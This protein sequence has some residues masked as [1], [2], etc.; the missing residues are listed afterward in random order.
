LDYDVTLNLY[1]ANLPGR[2]KSKAGRLLVMGCYQVVVPKFYKMQIQLIVYLLITLLLTFVTSTAGVHSGAAVLVETRYTD[3]LV[4]VINEANSYLPKNGWDIVVITNKNI[5]K[6]LKDTSTP[7]HHQKERK[8]IYKSIL[9]DTLDRN[10]Y[11]SLMKKRDLYDNTL[12]EYDWLIFFQTDTTFCRP[13]K[14]F[15][16]K[17]LSKFGYIGST[18]DNALVSPSK[19]FS[20]ATL[21]DHS[22]PR[23]FIHVGNGGFSLRNRK[24]MIDIIDKWHRISGHLPYNEDVW[25]ACG[26]YYNDILADVTTANEF[27]IES[28]PFNGQTMDRPFGV[29]KPWKYQPNKNLIQLIKACPPLKGLMSVNKITMKN[30]DVIDL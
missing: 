2:T 11:N 1:L 21:R 29:H 18:W 10:G 20:C 26:A 6:K 12:K 24:Q 8:I 14:L 23:A 22:L 4:F 28:I 15:E 27:S 17:S 5:V 3:A 13:F 7:L 19:G 9:N 25:F 30:D 16:W